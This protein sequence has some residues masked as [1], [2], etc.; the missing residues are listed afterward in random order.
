M[1]WPYAVSSSNTCAKLCTNIPR[2]PGSGSSRKKSRHFSPSYRKCLTI[3][4][5]F[6]G[7]RSVGTHFRRYVKSQS[8]DLNNIK[9]LCH[10]FPLSKAVSMLCHIRDT[11]VASVLHAAF[12]PYEIWGLQLEPAR[13]VFLITSVNLI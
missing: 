6:E 4:D 1:Y 10:R 5:R 7:L 12:V 11:R 9:W 2:S 8:Y 3:I 13:F